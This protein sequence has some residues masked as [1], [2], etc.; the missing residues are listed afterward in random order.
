[1]YCTVPAALSIVRVPRPTK[2]DEPAA[3]AGEEEAKERG[4]GIDHEAMAAAFAVAKKIRDIE[5]CLL[6][7]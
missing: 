2:K 7:F 3:T 1:M 5:T 6:H 4:D